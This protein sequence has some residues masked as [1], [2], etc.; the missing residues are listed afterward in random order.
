MDDDNEEEGRKEEGKKRKEEEKEERGRKEKKK[1]SEKRKNV[2]L[3][4]SPVTQV[5]LS[6]IHLTCSE[7]WGSQPTFLHL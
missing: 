1:L 3:E 6:L 7:I 5:P 2:N 4:F